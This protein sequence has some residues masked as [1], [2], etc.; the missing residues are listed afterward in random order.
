MLRN[1]TL[2][3]AFCSVISSAAAH[4]EYPDTADIYV[5]PRQEYVVIVGDSAFNVRF[6]EYKYFQ[7]RTL[8]FARES[9]QSFSGPKGKLVTS[10]SRLT[11]TRTEYSGKLKSLQ[12]RRADSK[13]RERWNRLYERARRS[14]D[15]VDS[16]RVA[17]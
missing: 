10:G 4:R 5:G 11:L 2:L 7:Y 14:M 1:I 13:D 16:Q 15:F 6:A 3:I 12:F 8:H 17:G 9:A